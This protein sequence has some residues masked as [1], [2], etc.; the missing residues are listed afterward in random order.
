M[1][2]DVSKEAVRIATE[3]LEA[4]DQC[5]SGGWTLDPSDIPRLAVSIQDFAR[6]E[7]ERL[8]AALA[9]Q[10]VPYEQLQTAVCDQEGVIDDLKTEN[11]R[12]RGALSDI[13][14]TGKSWC[15]RCKDS[16]YTKTARIAAKALGEL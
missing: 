2:L 5:Y 12:L 3:F 11:A 1:S 9:V 7:N 14:G 4:S 13:V 16:H 10:D 6:A 8:E 15:E